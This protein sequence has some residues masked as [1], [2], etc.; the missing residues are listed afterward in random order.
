MRTTRP[1]RRWWVLPIWIALAGAC[2]L[3]AS[4]LGGDVGADPGPDG[5]D[6]EVPPPDDAGDDLSDDAA[7][8]PACT[9]AAE[10]DDGI[11]CTVDTCPPETRRCTHEPDDSACDDHDACTGA[12]RCDPTSGCVSDAPVDCDD[13]LDCTNDRCDPATGGCLRT[14]VHERC[15]APQLCDPP[16]S[17]DASGCADPPAC[18]GDD[19]CADGDLCNGVETCGPE[20]LCRPG[21]EV[22]CND[23]IPCTIDS[24]Q[25]ATGACEH[26]APD[27]DGDT[28]TDAAC[29]GTDCDDTRREVRPGAPELC[30]G[31]DDDCDGTPDDAATCEPLPNATTR[32]AGGACVMT[33]DS[34]WG[35]CDGLR[36]NGCESSFSDPA[37]CGSCTTSCARPHAVPSCAG[38]TCGIA[39]CD[40]GWGDCNT[41]ASDGCER[42]LTTPFDC[43]ACFVPCAPANTTGPDCT[44]GTCG[45]TSCNPGWLDCNGNTGDGCE[46]L[47]G[48]V[49]AACRVSCDRVVDCS[50]LPN[51]SGA[52]CAGSGCTITGCADGYAECNDRVEDGCERFLDAP[53]G[54]CSAATNLGTIYGDSGS[55]RLT[56]TRS[57]Q[58][59]YSFRLREYHVTSGYYPLT[60]TIQ[61]DVPDGVDYDIYVLCGASGCASASGPSGTG[62]T[63]QDETVQIRW[64]DQDGDTSRTVY[65][66]VDFYSGSTLG[67]GDWTVTIT[68]NTSVAAPTC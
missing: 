58:G 67:C 44:T 25:P 21:T 34:G 16:R 26:R 63:G 9:G 17:A 56:A 7:E 66:R 57:G 27:V 10:C 46:A 3:D 19:D 50:A 5:F 53:E 1:G 49:P 42:P 12:E 28:H 35:D 29:Y 43:G 33:C 32:C 24:C 22:V 11:A 62:P 64:N 23:S 13:G 45:Y 38:G 2:G 41:L 18:A 20:L 4:G 31:R 14:L 59:W 54:T 40:S 60:A 30:N 68:G 47:A 8:A 65:F 55:G 15:T 37:T 51:V 61:L 48:G 39:G 52:G 36:P 6:G